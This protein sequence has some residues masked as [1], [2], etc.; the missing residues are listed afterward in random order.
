LAV[1]GHTRL[2]EKGAETV[3]IVQGLALLGEVA[4]GLDAVLEAV[5][6]LGRSG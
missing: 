3:V 5:E 6:L 2:G 1:R 4:I